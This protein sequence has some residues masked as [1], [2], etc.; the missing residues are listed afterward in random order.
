M[1]FYRHVK[2]GITGKTRGVTGA[3]EQS[4]TNN[5]SMLRW[6]RL[7]LLLQR[8]GMQMKLTRNIIVASQGEHERRKE[9]RNTAGDVRV[10]PHL[11][12][13]LHGMSQALT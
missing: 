8:A 12:K 2:G 6:K 7:P 11:T 13:M 9:S 10:S 5:S 3:G 4:G 1:S